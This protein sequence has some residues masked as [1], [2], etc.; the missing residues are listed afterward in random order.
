[1]RNK[2]VL[3]DS[4]TTYFIF[5]FLFRILKSEHKFINQDQSL[6]CI[7]FVNAEISIKNSK[8]Q[9][10]ARKQDCYDHISG[11]DLHQKCF[12]S[13]TWNLK[14]QLFLVM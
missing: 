9:S 4:S 1:M 13:R 8:K 7:Y 3:Q 10:Q 11:S 12:Y 6:T 14:D 5:V 2:H